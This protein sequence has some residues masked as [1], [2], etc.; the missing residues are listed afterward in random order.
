MSHT[1]L[2]LRKCYEKFDTDKEKEGFKTRIASLGIRSVFKDVSGWL[3]DKVD[4]K[5]PRL[6]WH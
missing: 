3:R 4:F 1:S 6:A 2:G 5:V